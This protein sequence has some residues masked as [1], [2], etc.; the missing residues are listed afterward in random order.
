MKL[1]LVL[2][3]VAVGAAAPQNPQDVQILRYDIDNTGLEAYSYAVELSDGTKQEEQG[4]LKNQGTENESISVQGQYSW[5]GPDGVV[6]TVSYIAD[7]NGFQPRI[8]QGPG[9]SIPSGVIAS[10]LG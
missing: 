9:G 7:E 2:V 5:V 3:F 10:F 6:Y 8:E 4:Q 1:F